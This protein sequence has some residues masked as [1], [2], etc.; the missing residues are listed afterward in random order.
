[1]KKLLL[2][3]GLMLVSFAEIFAA[4]KPA[5]EAF[6][7]CG[8]MNNYAAPTDANKHRFEYILTDEDGDGIYT[9]SF[10]IPKLDEKLEFNL[11][12]EPLVRPTEWV[13]ENIWGSYGD[14][15]LFNTPTCSYNNNNEIFLYNNDG[16]LQFP[17]WEGGIINLKVEWVFDEFFDK[18]IPVL[19]IEA[20][21]QP[22]I[23]AI[24][25]LYIIGDFNDWK[26][27]SASNSQGAVK[28]NF[29][30]YQ[31]TSIYMGINFELEKSDFTSFAFCQIDNSD[32]VKY[33][34]P[35]IN[36]PVTMYGMDYVGGSNR[37]SFNYSGEWSDDFSMEKSTFKIKE[38]PGGSFYTYIKF[39]FDNSGVTGGL[40][41]NPDINTELPD[42]L[43]MISDADGVKTIYEVQVH[44]SGS[45]ISSGR[46][47]DRN[48]SVTFTTEN[49][50]NPAPENCYGIPENINLQDLINYK[51]S[52][53]FLPLVKGGK[54]FSYIF[55]SDGW[56]NI[57]LNLK[58]S[59]A[60]ISSSHLNSII[61]DKLYI[62]GDVMNEPDGVAN[63]FMTPAAGNQDMYDQYFQLEKHGDTFVGTFY[64]PLKN[65]IYDFTFPEYLPQ[66]RFFT[67]LLGWRDEASYG[68]Y[69]DD[70]YCLPVPLE[71]GSATL[72]IVKYG[73]GNWGPCIDNTWS[74]SWVKMTVYCDTAKLK[75][76]LTDSGV[77]D[78]I[79]DNQPAEIESEAWYNLQGIRVDNPTKGMYI[80]ITNGRSRVELVK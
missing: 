9:G 48:I 64:I 23:P 3:L 38:W 42:K 24:P 7:L 66:F 68:S 65:N 56:M 34:N 57:L 15:Y 10:N 77:N 13:A 44:D 72:D 1:M 6:Y 2:L 5:N 26:T 58:C 32:K 55:P 45:W 53:T 78:I 60:R 18:W 35:D 4:E 12:Q 40:E 79:N 28:F 27:P 69:R 11:I 80:H 46:I 16:M 29:N 52:E 70:F 51:T 43:Y 33:Y 71:S 36:F 75:L 59:I 76:E 22:D 74:G 31:W 8:N 47:Y 67:E 20:P 37:P 17:N 39:P 73:L 61:S 30:D 14:Y 54:P 41:G 50:L 49:S 63:N 19:S 21:M 25:E 62:C